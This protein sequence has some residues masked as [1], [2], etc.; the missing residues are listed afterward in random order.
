MLKIVSLL[1][2]NPTLTRQQF[3]T[4]YETH[5]V[6]LVLGFVGDHLH[7]YCRNF[8]VGDLVEGDLNN[9]PTGI[10]GI[11]EL[12]FASEADLEAAT[13]V[14]QRPQVAE[15]VAADESI[16]LDRGAIRTYLVEEHAS[17]LHKPTT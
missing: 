11:T 17:E 1:K 4:Y 13:E 2:R 14:M 8:V 5:H 3:I 12:W 10:D 7:G 16:F 6:P 9:L 15:R